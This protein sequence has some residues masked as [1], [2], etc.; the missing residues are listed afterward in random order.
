[1]SLIDDIFDLQDV[2][3]GKPEYK[4]LR[5]IVDRLDEAEK[6]RDQMAAIAVPF[7]EAMRAAGGISA[8]EAAE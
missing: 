3:Y 1:M 2:L 8:W 7:M 4:A 5:R 6:E